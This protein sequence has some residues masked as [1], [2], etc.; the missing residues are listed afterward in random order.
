M[1]GGVGVNFAC[2]SVP[3]LKDLGPPDSIHVG[4]VE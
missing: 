4:G 3:S 2:K 1:E